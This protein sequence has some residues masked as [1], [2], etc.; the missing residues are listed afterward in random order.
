MIGKTQGRRPQGPQHGPVYGPVKV[1]ASNKGDYNVGAM[2]LRTHGTCEE[3]VREVT[4]EQA[5]EMAQ[6]IATKLE[7]MHPGQWWEPYVRDR[8]WDPMMREVD[9]AYWKAR[10]RT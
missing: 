4:H 3:I 9:A 2:N 7:G 8:S 5:S 10:G 6:K 1:F